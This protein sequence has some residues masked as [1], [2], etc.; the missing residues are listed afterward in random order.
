MNAL[1]AANKIN[2]PLLLPENKINLPL[3]LLFIVMILLALLP[4]LRPNIGQPSLDYIHVPA[5]G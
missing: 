1:A 4:Q 5:D 2:L 3:L